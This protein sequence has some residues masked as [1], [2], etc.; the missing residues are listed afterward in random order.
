MAPRGPADRP[1]SGRGPRAGQQAGNDLQDAKGKLQA[2]EGC[3]PVSE[4]WGE[5]SHIP[6]KYG[7]VNTT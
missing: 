7:R 4:K 3:F 2:A 1:L 5:S 6:A